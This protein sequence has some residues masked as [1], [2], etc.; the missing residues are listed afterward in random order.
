MNRIEK[1]LFNK[2]ATDDDYNYVVNYI[3]WTLYFLWYKWLVNK[4]EVTNEMLIKL[5]EKKDTYDTSVDI[6]K[7]K[8][9][10]QMYLIYALQEVILTTWHTVNIPM[11]MLKWNNTGVFSK[12][13]MELLQQL[14]VKEPEDVEDKYNFK[15]ELFNQA[16]AE[17]VQGLI[18]SN[19]T[20]REK[21]IL[22]KHYILDISQP[23]IAREYW[24]TQQRVFSILKWAKSKFKFDI[25]SNC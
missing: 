12:N 6:R 10:I 22:T 9:Y 11:H 16:D 5:W 23:D 19:L 8:K 21:D 17:F 3:E 13:S 4:Y 15:Q 2:D 7:R 25:K 18:L 24:I 14:Y 1:L 20:D